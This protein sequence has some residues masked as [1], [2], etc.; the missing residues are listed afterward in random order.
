MSNKQWQSSWPKKNQGQRWPQK[1]KRGK[2]TNPRDH[3]AMPSYDSVSS[4]GHASGSGASTD[5]KDTTDHGLRGALQELFMQNNMEVPEKLKEFF[6]PGVGEELQR[7]QRELNQ[8]RKISQRLQRLQAALKR[9]SEQWTTFRQN[10]REHVQ[11]EKQRYEEETQELE[12]AIAS[13]K[14]DLEKAMKGEPIQKEETPAP[15]PDLDFM[16]FEMDKTQE[17]TRQG[18]DLQEMLQQ[19]SVGQQLLA[20]QVQ[21]MQTQMQYMVQTI[22]PPEIQSPTRT[23]MPLAAGLSPPPVTPEGTRRRGPLEPFAR[24]TERVDGYGPYPKQNGQ[25]KPESTIV[26]DGLESL[27]GYGPAK[28]P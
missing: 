27:D 19:T 15:D 25:D 2:D 26:V 4:Q 1:D 5:R 28:G 12:K 20:R 9:K 7:D 3:G 16:E 8:K 14:E 13:T 22:L 18:T 23:T 21:E 11:K 6:Q 24:K 10:I 17:G